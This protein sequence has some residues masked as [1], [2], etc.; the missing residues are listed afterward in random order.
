MRGQAPLFRGS[1]RLPTSGIDSTLRGFRARAVCIA[2]ASLPVLGVLVVSAPAVPVHASAATITAPTYV[3]TIGTNGESTMY[4]SGVAVDATGNVYVADTGNYQVEKYQAGTTTRLWSVGVRGAPV[5][6]TTDSFI[7]PRDIATDN[8]HVFVADTDNADVQELNASDGSFV[9]SFHLFGPGNADSF[10]DPIGISVGQSASHAEEILVSDGVTGNVYVFN[11]AFSLQFTVPPNPPT[12]TTEGTRDAATDSA[13]NIYTADYRGNAVDKYSPTGTYITSFGTGVAGC[14]DVAKP[15]GVDIDTA[16]TPNRV[17]VASSNLEQVKVFDT[18]GNCLNVGATGSNA[19]GAAATL[20]N[21]PTKLFQLRRVAVGAGANPLIY[22]ADLWGL[23]ILTYNSSDGTIA[24][25]Q[26]P[27]LGSGTYP[28]LGGLNEDHGIAIDPSTSQI[29]VANTVNQRIER[30]NLP[31]GDSPFNWGTK[32]VDSATFNWAQGIG[33]DPQDGNV[34]VA[35]TR[36]NR[37]DE[38]STDGTPISSCP[39]TSRLTSSFN[40]PMAVAFDPA[41][42]MYVADTFNNRIEAIDVSKC[43]GS[44]VPTLWSVGTRGSGSGQFIKPWDIAYDPT[45]NRL[46]VT[47]TNNSRIVALNPS[48]GAVESL[49]PTITKGSAP[50]QVQLPE[51]I[52]VDASGNIWVADTGNNRVEEFTGAGTFANQMVGTYGCCFNAPNTDLNAPQELAF[53]T[54]GLL[55]VADAN[56]NRIQVFQP[57]GSAPFGPPGPYT[58]VTPFR[59]CDTRPIGPGVS[60]NQCNSGSGAHGPLGPGVARSITAG[61]TGSHVPATGVSAVVVNLTAIAPTVSTFLT[62]Y[63]SSGALPSTSNITPAAGKVI[64]NL[65]EVALSPGGQFNVFNAAGTTNV[66]IDIEGYVPATTSGTTGLYNPTTPTRICDTR[67]TRG[68]TLNQCD[69]TG[70][71]PIVVGHPLTLDVHGSGSPVPSTGVSAVVFNLTAISPTADSVLTA[72][73]TG[74]PAPQAS[75]INV[76]AGGVVPNR[77]IVPV[78]A[79]CAAPNCK[80]TIETS[81]GSVDVAVDIDGWFTDNTGTQGGSLFSGVAPSRLCDTRYGNS[82]DPG[83]DKAQVSAGARRRPQHP[84]C[85]EGGHTVDVQRQPAGSRGGEP[86]RCWGDDR[87]VRDRVLVGRAQSATSVRRQ[88]AGGS[89]RHQPRR[90]PGGLRWNH[91]PVQ[92]GGERGY[93][94]RCLRVLRLVIRPH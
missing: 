55:Y 9:T 8:V 42:T 84:G 45:Q 10:Q 27:L 14:A 11:T 30:F 78:P 77:V 15:Y 85:R 76:L 82:N 49:F 88:C 89:G 90:R 12:N 91:Q 7:A 61:V 50:G 13:G 81:A 16:D 41:G 2:A 48:N 34:W 87:H 22:A 75:N 46:L 28:A 93:H 26:Q 40:W 86:H 92:R 17:Y 36:N 18:S 44:T 57:S 83:C 38:F 51:G 63:P 43:T 32:G 79:H 59:I 5:G 6:P 52:A 23:K 4:P 70:H 20:S 73:P 74:A 53:D 80:V 33:Y 72:F 1:R 71:R 24:S 47:D 37:I 25:S 3:R 69:L 94:R 21:D 62:V 54:N 58:G 39:N 60:A 29:F 67:S 68:I 56:N 65:V 35:N 31:N 19:I 66:A 64:A